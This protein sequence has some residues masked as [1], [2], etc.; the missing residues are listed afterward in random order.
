[1]RG[2]NNNENTVKYFKSKEFLIVR[3]QIVEFYVNTVQLSFDLIAI[4]VL[5]STKLT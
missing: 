4:T 5:L 2:R 3:G 1:M